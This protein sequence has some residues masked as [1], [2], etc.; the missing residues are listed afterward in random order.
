MTAWRYVYR[1]KAVRVIDGDGLLVCLDMGVHISAAIPIRL[2]GCNAAE[3][4]TVAGQ[5][6]ITY[7]TRWVAEHSDS[8]GWLLVAT[9][10]NPEDPHGRWLADVESL[11]GHANLTAD[12][13]AAGHAVAWNGRG[14][15]PVPAQA[16]P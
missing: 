8:D 3:K 5:N 15:K 9:H 4:A 12:L 6:A 7:V 10:K 1:A 16:A 11:D 14:T 13:I 2:R